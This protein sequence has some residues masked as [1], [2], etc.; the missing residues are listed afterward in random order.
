M[1]SGSWRTGW[2]KEMERAWRLMLNLKSYIKVYEKTY[3][4]AYRSPER[5]PSRL[6]LHMKSM[7]FCCTGLARRFK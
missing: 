2:M 1:V 7:S 6:R 3:G 5:S 4:E